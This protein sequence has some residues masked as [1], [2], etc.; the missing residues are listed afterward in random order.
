MAAGAGPPGGAVRGARRAAPGAGVFP[1]V[2]PPPPP[3]PRLPRGSLPTPSAVF[4]ARLGLSAPA[5]AALL[6][7]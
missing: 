2:S 1:E 6:L 3:P 5:P 4:M 7:G